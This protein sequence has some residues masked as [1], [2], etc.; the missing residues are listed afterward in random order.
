[1]AFNTP[2]KLAIIKQKP[3]NPSTE[4]WIRPGDW[5]TVTD[6][7]GEVQFLAS[8]VLNATY[9]LQTAFIKPASQNL[10]IDWGDGTTDTI[11]TNTDV[12]T[13]HTYAVGTG[14]ACSRGYTTFKIRVYVDAGATIDVCKFRAQ[15]YNG[16]GGTEEYA[17]NNPCGLLEAYYGDNTLPSLGM[18]DYF[19]DNTILILFTY[20]EYVKCPDTMNYNQGLVSTFATTTSSGGCPALAKVVM[21][22]NYSGVTMLFNSTFNGCAN[23]I[24]V[25]FPTNVTMENL[26]G[27]FGGCTKL[28]SITLP[29]NMDAC[30]TIANAF[31]NCYTLGSIDLPALPAC[32]S[33]ASAFQN[34][35]SLTSFNLKSFT[36]TAQTINLSNILQNCGSLVNVN[37]PAT[38]VSGTVLTL[39]N[40]FGNCTSLLAI[41]I[42]EINIDS[43]TATFSG[44][45]NL[46]SVTLPTSCPSLTTLATAFNAC[47]SLGEITLP[48]TVTSGTIAMNS[49]F[50]NCFSLSSITIPSSYNISTLTLIFSGCYNLITANLP[51][52]AQNS[53]TTLGSSFLN[54]YSLINLTLPTSLTGCTS[55]VSAFNGCNS[56]ESISL[57]ATMN[58]CTS[59]GSAFQ[60]C[61]SL[62]SLTLPTSMTALTTGGLGG[63]FGGCIS[64]KNLVFPA[65]VSTG[66]TLINAINLAPGLPSLETVTFPTTQTTA[67]TTLANNFNYCPGLTGA[68]NVD[69]L[70]N[71]STATT[72]YVTGTTIMGP[73]Q[74]ARRLL[75]LDFTCKF[76]T[77]VFNG[78]VTKPL[79]LNSL[80]LRNSGTGQY[81]GAS[82]QINVS[83]T[84]LG[85]AAL[86]Q[87]FTDLP[88]ITSKTINITG[89]PGAATCTRSIATAKG[90]TVTG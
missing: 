48:T 2:S 7:A 49:A 16:T 40:A 62:T 10:Y 68:F 52:N 25:N 67:I 64:L 8:D 39:S 42:P 72:T 12:Y 11:S 20:L 33:Y 70:G 6:V 22:T 69:K 23:L 58:S 77:F 32:V 80:R 37:L 47:N 26:S 56:L 86:N 50:T 43:L 79:A 75:S 85:T 38:S 24:E 9:N 3:V 53:L 30:T 27:T 4:T 89:T 5:P 1:M 63:T 15:G 82:P 55:L 61:Y 41:T 46:Q 57:P 54:C 83:Y 81:A 88:T 28:R 74:A 44:C 34:C 78:T 76:S 29:S 84:S 45:S 59:M 21:P 51:N 73:N 36:S 60:Y 87:L 13:S 71:N 35:S 18:L 31:Q 90:W 65:T 19:R 17:V 14:T 66:L